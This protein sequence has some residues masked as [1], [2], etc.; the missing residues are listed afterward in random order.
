MTRINHEEEFIAI[1]KTALPKD[2]VPKIEELDDAILRAKQAAPIMGI[3]LSEEEIE[4][5][6]RKLQAQHDVEIG[7]GSYLVDKTQEPWLEQA[8]SDIDPFYWDRYKKY[9]LQ[10][11]GWPIPVVKNLDEETDKIL[12]LCGNPKKETHWDRRG[13]VMGHVQSGKTAN[14]TGLICK[15]ADAGYK[16]IIIIAGIQ[17]SLRNQT[18]IRVDEGFTGYDSLRISS[19]I[20]NDAPIGVGLLSREE[21]R[22]PF[23]LT[24]SKQD[25]NR[26]KSEL[27][28]PLDS[29]K[30][31]VVLVVKKNASVLKNLHDWL[32]LN[33]FTP[34]QE[35]ISSPLLLIDDEADNASI[36]IMYKK[37]EVSTINKAIRSILSLFQHST[38]VGYTATPFANVFIDPDTDDEMISDDLFPRSFIVSLDA[39]SNYFGAERIFL[40]EPSRFIINNEDALEPLPLKHRKEHRL[41]YLPETLKEAIRCFVLATAIRGA[42]NQEKEHSSMM[43]NVSRFVAVQKN[44]K[45][46]VSLYLDE[47]VDSCKIYSALPWQEAHGDSN[48]NELRQT[49]DKFYQECGEEWDSIQPILGKTAPEI[50][51]ALVNSGSNDN[52]NY[53]DYPEGK[54]VIAVGGMSLSRGLTLEGLTISYY[55]RNS[56]MYDTLIQMGR[57]FGYRSGYEDLCRIFMTSESEGHFAHVTESIMELRDEMKFMQSQGATPEEF[58]LKVRSDPNT[59]IITAANKMGKS[60]D[61][62]W[63]VGLANHFIESTRLKRDQHTIESNRALAKKLAMGVSELS[64]PELIGGGYLFKNAPY[65]AVEDFFSTFKGSGADIKADTRLIVEY[66]RRGREHELAEWDVFFPGVKTSRAKE[67]LIEKLAD[68]ITIQCQQRGVDESASTEDVLVHKKLRVASRPVEDVGLSKEEKAQ[69]E[70]EFN[71]NERKSEKQQYPDKIYRRKRKKPLLIVHLIDYQVEKQP[72]YERGIPVVAWSLS[73]PGTDRKEATLEYKINAVFAK[74]QLSLFDLDIADDE[75]DKDEVQYV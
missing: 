40:D 12:Q 17:N 45:T 23:S 70:K 16:I 66:L 22:W 37:D 57:W 48:L 61:L 9:L 4:L 3:N 7:F 69:A 71:E 14:Y 47:L 67:P 60:E 31:P 13:L 62:V 50:S 20:N 29:L 11:K 65:E 64:D 19:D 73:L 74:Q 8:K 32:K 56:V 18:Q 58:G 28:T 53:Q 49:F 46:F 68:N 30:E 55:L 59:L 33:G 63:R 26:S 43:V 34:R 42:S 72:G 75:M 21:N 25:F 1:V 27:G 6:K 10:D 41:D 35:H 51:V 44:V 39:P 15:A 54:K 5:I 24:N 52:L 38:Y 2:E 36:N